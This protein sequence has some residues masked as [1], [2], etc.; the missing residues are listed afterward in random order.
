[1]CAPHPIPANAANAR[2][3]TPR[4]ALAVA[5][6]NGA[7][8]AVT[9]MPPIG[10]V[11]ESYALP[12]PPTPPAV[13]DIDALLDREERGDIIFGLVLL[14]AFAAMFAAFLLA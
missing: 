4:A 12:V 7:A 2:Y 1:M 13:E 3:Y 5:I 9:Q 14:T 11:R 6:Q 10:T 8:D